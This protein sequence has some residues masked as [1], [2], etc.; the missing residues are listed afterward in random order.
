MKIIDGLKH[1]QAQKLISLCGWKPRSLP[2]IVD[3]KDRQCKSTGNH[4]NLFHIVTNMRTPSTS[5]HSSPDNSMPENEDLV[6]SSELQAKHSVVLECNLCGATVGLW[7]FSTV[8]RPTEFLRI[9]GNT[10]VSGESNAFHHKETDLYPVT[11]AP[12]IHDSGKENHVNSAEAII[13]TDSSGT[14]SSNGRSLN[15]NLTIAGGPPPTEQNFR[16]TISIPVIGQN[17]RAWFTSE[18]D[19]RDRSCVNKENLEGRKHTE[20]NV[21]AQTVQP[22]SMGLQ[23]IKGHGDCQIIAPSNDQ[24]PC[25][26]NISKEDEIFTDSNSHMPLD[27][28]NVDQQE[29]GFPETGM[30]DSFIKDQSDST[31]D[32]V[33]TSG[34]YHKLTECADDVEMINP[35][36]VESADNVKTVN[37]TATG[38]ADDIGTV[39][40][41]ATESADNTETVNPTAMDSPNN[42]VRDS[43]LSSSDANTTIKN[44]EVSEDDLLMVVGLDDCN[45]R[46]I[47]GTDNVC[48]ILVQGENH[49]EVLNFLNTQPNSQVYNLIKDRQHVPVNNEGVAS[50]A[51]KD[52]FC[53]SSCIL[54]ISVENKMH[55]AF[56]LS[57]T[58]LLVHQ[59][60]FIAIVI[61]LS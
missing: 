2:Y 12:G 32:A 44:S 38:S 9:V 37:P 14:R 55:I 45:L 11:D 58:F 59:S 35:I 26:N 1:A 8:P 15:L 7:A 31:Q 54:I 5:I 10:E 24:S 42:E 51:G 48:N 43:C 40:P 36:P 6:A 27:R 21:T 49:S 3:T 18:H 25:L 53:L 29:L 34:Q 61:L 46:Q 33:K 16:A 22:E 39:N 19:V 41:T 28:P 52:K 56:L 47:H 57:S 17:L 60:I 13:I 50:Y 4:F 30:P 23:E 20:N